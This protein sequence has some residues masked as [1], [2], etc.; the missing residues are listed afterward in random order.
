LAG[1]LLRDIIR[2][3]P[4]DDVTV[5]TAAGN[6]PALLLYAAA[7]FHDHRRWTTGDGIPMVTLRRRAGSRPPGA[8]V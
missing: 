5:S 6:G 3:H 2:A 7:G 4:S 1:A 8:A